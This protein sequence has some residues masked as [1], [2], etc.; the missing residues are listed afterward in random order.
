MTP[1]ECAQLL[2][3][4]ADID[5][6]VKPREDAV[7]SWMALLG[8]LGYAEAEDA[9]R[10]HYEST[11]L[12]IMPADIRR[13]C[14]TRVDRAVMPPTPPVDPDDVEKFIAW[15]RAWLRATGRGWDAEKAHAYACRVTGVPDRPTAGN[16]RPPNLGRVFRAVPTN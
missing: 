2:A 5:H 9:V 10:R 11:G 12:A 1:T 4:V 7:H 3:L 6:R 15:Q 8:D 16:H 13:L 14:R